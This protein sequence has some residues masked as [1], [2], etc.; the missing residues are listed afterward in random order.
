MRDCRSAL[1]LCVMCFF[2]ADMLRFPGFGL[3]APPLKLC[4]ALPGPEYQSA[5]KFVLLRP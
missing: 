2:W 5:A 4:Q 3:A 1:S